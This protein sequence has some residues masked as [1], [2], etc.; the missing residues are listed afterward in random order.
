MKQNYLNNKDLL[1]E[2]HLSKNSYCSY[3]S[4]DDHD[5]DIILP[6]LNRVNMRTLAQAKRNRAEK[7]QKR[8]YTDAIAEGQK[9]KLADFFMNWKKITK[10]E[11]T[12]RISTFDH[13]PLEPGRKKNPK[14]VADFHIK[15]NFPPFQ[16]F[17]FLDGELKCVGKSHWEGGL[18]NGYFRL[19]G[20]N[21][22]EKLAISFM[23]LCERYG[24]RGNWRGYCVDESTEALT[25]QGWLNY[26]KITEKDI[27]LSFDGEQ[28]KWSKIKSIFQDD[29]NGA[30]HKITTK[31]GIDMLVTP[32]H[33]LVTERGLV[34][35]EHILEKDRI[36][37]IGQALQNTVETY[38][39]SFVELVG[40]IVTEGNYEFRNDKIYCVSIWQNEGEHAERIRNCLTTLN[41]QYSEHKK[42]K[43]I[44][45]RII[46]SDSEK[47]LNDLPEK[48]LSMD[49]I[50]MLTTQ[51]RE[52]LINT[53]VDG[54]GWR[55]SHLMRYCQ[56]NKTHIDLF[57]ALCFM[58][59]RRSSVRL[60]DHWSFDKPTSCFSMNLF[61]SRKNY[62]RGECLN[63]HGGKRNGQSHPGQ[64]KLFH[65]NEPMTQ[66]KGKVWCPETEYGC[67]VARRNNSVY[68]TGNTYNDEM[69]GQA[70]VHLVQVGLQFDES[71]SLNPFAWYTQVVTNSFTRVLNIEK[72]NQNI[73]D[74]ILESHGIK[75]SYTRQNQ[76]MT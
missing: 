11:L 65:P 14:V 32:N 49:F 72:K 70:L 75:P 7:L 60:R 69:Q 52:L 18:Q 58:S 31:T 9:V 24:G 46:K 17:R 57:Q 8:A 67:F 71:K 16:H 5:Y 50:T 48:N 28:L 21:I 2:I 63:F 74:D 29:F 12:I 25:Q 64:G 1:K 37:L 22:T 51:Q 76:P 33:K 59:G 36:I 41:Y 38:S 47:I 3:L 10:E 35:V 56:K 15:T 43:N 23:K 45:F 73:R 13:I 20:G 4:S 34:P 62:T 19:D 26:T 6:N 44:R 40:W 66:Y 27:I 53:M 54:D 30:M 42:N 61:S 68:L 55:N 39:D